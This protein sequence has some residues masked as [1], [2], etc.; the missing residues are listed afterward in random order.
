MSTS[1]SGKPV[2]WMGPEDTHKVIPVAKVRHT[3]ICL[4][5]GY[6]HK[7]SM[8]WIVEAE[9]LRSDTPLPLPDSP[10]LCFVC[11]S[12]RLVRVRVTWWGGH[13]TRSA[14]GPQ[15]QHRGHATSTICVL[16]IQTFAIVNVVCDMRNVEWS[17]AVDAPTFS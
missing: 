16:Y 3:D 10:C 8:R 4:M 13:R 17:V 15:V 14:T 11:L 5:Y 6:I 9:S 12:E 2:S 1:I 7:T